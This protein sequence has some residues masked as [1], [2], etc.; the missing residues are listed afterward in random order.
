MTESELT[1]L[2]S[3][4]A[5]ATSGPWEARR[6][7]V[8]VAN[9]RSPLPNNFMM[10]QGLIAGCH[11]TIGKIEREEENAEFI[12]AARTATIELIAEVRRLR[13]SLAR[14]SKALVHNVGDCGYCDTA[15]AISED[16]KQ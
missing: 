7:S 2:E 14:V 4:A 9:Y 6:A 15:H 16:A 10:W 12:A 8:Y 1:R 13:A 5:A 11:A 3:L